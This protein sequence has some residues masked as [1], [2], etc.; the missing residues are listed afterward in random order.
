[1]QIKESLLQEM[2]DAMKAKDEIKKNT[3][4]MVRA[5][6][7]QVE[8]DQLKTLTEE[9][10]IEI[11]AKESKKR[12]ESKLEY[13]KTDRNDIVEDLE[14]EIEILSKYLPEQLSE[15]KIK[16]IVEQTIA[17]LGA[18]GIKDMG[19]VMKDVKVKTGASADGK[20]V[21]DIVKELLSK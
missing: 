11:I 18:T 2:K 16:K 1:M 6:I 17:D 20:I 19:M 12:K 21:S 8:K 9:E 5:A 4:T 7:L 10:M 13:E 15:E 14:K 3:I